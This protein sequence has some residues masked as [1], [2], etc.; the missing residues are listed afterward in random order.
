MIHIYMPYI[1]KDRKS[2]ACGRSPTS[3]FQHLFN[4]SARNFGQWEGISGFKPSLTTL[5]A[6][7]TRSSVGNGTVP[8]TISK[9]SIPYANM[10]DPIEYNPFVCTSGAMKFCV[11][12]MLETTSGE[13]IS[14]AK[15]KSHNFR[16][17]S[18]KIKQLAGLISLWRILRPCK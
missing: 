5:Y 4:R 14:L 15:P 6:A 18:Q 13:S 8:E 7:V 2:F 12:L 16:I 1:P 3:R 10:S 9:R 11:P 17:L